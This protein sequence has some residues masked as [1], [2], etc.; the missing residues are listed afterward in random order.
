V[1]GLSYFREPGYF[2]GGMILTYVFTA[3]A[4]LVV[5]LFAIFAFGVRLALED[6]RLFLWLAGAVLLTML[7]V[8]PAYSLWLSLDFWIAPWGPPAHCETVP[9]DIFPAPRGSRH[10]R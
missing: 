4:L 2:I 9:P 1:C 6:L 8:R 7:F 3:I 5:Y 10:W